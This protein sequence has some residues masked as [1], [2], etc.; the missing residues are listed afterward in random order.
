MTESRRK[1]LFDLWLNAAKHDLD[2][3]K[4]SIGL[5]EF[6]G[7]CFLSQQ[8]VEKS[9]K[10]FLY[11]KGEELKK[12]HDLDSLLSLTI[13]Y[14]KG[15]AKYIEATST[16]NSYYLMT[17]YPDIGNVELFNK[18][19]LAEKALSWAEEIFEFVKSLQ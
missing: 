17:R 1:E 8:I 11:F 10:A 16:L 18:K 9:L 6:A 15:F 12:I 13:K 19:E 2:W 5:K 4:G 3:A 14:Y 7:V